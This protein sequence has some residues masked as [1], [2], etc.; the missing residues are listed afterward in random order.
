MLVY[1][2]QKTKP[3]DPIPNSVITQP[4]GL[5]AKSLIVGIPHIFSEFLNFDILLKYFLNFKNICKPNFFPYWGII[6]KDFT[7]IKLSTAGR[8]LF[9]FCQ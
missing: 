6:D 2:S 7:S 8:S 9:N 1:K 3:Y 4:Y 5:T